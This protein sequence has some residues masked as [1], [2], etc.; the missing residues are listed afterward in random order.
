[1]LNNKFLT[2]LFA[3]ASSSAFS[4]VKGD[5]AVIIS[6]VNFDQVVNTFLDKGFKIDKID[7]D[8]KTLKTEYLNYRPDYNYYIYFD[9]R[10]KDSTAT[11]T[12]KVKNFDLEL[13]IQ[14]YKHGIYKYSFEDMKGIATSLNGQVKYTKK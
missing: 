9:V 7:K 6:G 13:D 2:L 4:Q 8:Y 11:I 5:N 10:V 14:N 3:L 1:M 12:G